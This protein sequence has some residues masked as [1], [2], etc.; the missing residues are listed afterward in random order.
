MSEAVYYCI[1]CGAS[2]ADE[3]TLCDKCEVNSVV[4]LEDLSKDGLLRA[5]ATK[6]STLFSDLRSAA[7]F[8]ISSLLAIGVAF[9]V[10]RFSG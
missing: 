1:H 4:H 2:Y 3:T 6:P 8:F 9:L 10:M 7:I 5:L